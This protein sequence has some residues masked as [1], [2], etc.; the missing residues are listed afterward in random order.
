MICSACNQEKDTSNFRKIKNYLLKCCRSCEAAKRKQYLKDHPEK[1][2][3]KYTASKKKW[4]KNNI[5][6]RK[7]Y[8]QQYYLNHKEKFSDNSKKESRRRSK[9]IYK[10]NKLKDPCYRLRSNISNAI[11]KALKG[12]SKGSITKYLDYSIAQLKAHLESQFDQN[13]SWENYG[14]YWHLD[15]II[16]QSDLPYTSMQDPNFAICWSL[17]NLR[18]LEAIQNLKDGASRIRHNKE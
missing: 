12:K 14:P 17:S 16:P 9:Y 4:L 2:K 3:Q 13:M 5:E 1:A 15:H 11:Y 10:K 18:P 7:Q 6:K 8:E